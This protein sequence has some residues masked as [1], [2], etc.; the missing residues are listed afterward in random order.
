MT[1]HSIQRFF[2]SP[3]IGLGISVSEQ[4][5]VSP[6]RYQCGPGK[7]DLDERRRKYRET[8]K[9]FEDALSSGAEIE[10]RAELVNENC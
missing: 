7:W 5:H 10:F 6:K 8:Y 2:F 9:L 4:G 1:C 3:D